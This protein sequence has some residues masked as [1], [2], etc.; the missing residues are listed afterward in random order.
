MLHLLKRKGKC[1]VE[2]YI[3]IF[4]KIVK[5]LFLI[6]SFFEQVFIVISNSLEVLMSKSFVLFSFL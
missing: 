3:I 1:Y 6:R 4:Y 2:K 5:L